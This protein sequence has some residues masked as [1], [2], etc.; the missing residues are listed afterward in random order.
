M[1]GEFRMWRP[2]LT[3]DDDPIVRM[4][5]ALNAEDPGPAPVPADNMRRT[6]RVLRETPLRGHAMV[7]EVDGRVCGYALLI[8]FWSNELGGD[9]CTIDELFAEPAHR[10]SGHATQLFQALSGRTEPWMENVAA[11]SLETTPANTRALRFYQRLGFRG[12][13]LTMHWRLSS[14]QR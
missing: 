12:R 10:G 7:L 11:L 9:V 6:L 13:N 5:L 3:V 4:C 14:T 2:A 1:A 8:S